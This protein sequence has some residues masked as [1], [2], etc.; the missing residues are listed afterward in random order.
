M[1]HPA[2]IKGRSGTTDCVRGPG[3]MVR[4]LRSI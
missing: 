2:R 3:Q 1:Y 4:L